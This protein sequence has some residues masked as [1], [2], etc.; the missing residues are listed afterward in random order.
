M[1]PCPPFL[2][3]RNAE[4]PLGHAEAMPSSPPQLLSPQGR[5]GPASPTPSPQ[6]R[7]PGA[8]AS[9]VQQCRSPSVEQVIEASSSEQQ[10][11]QARIQQDPYLRFMEGYTS[12]I[13]PDRMQEILVRM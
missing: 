5:G 9:P 11:S 3:Q 8:L 1:R 7:E 6:S 2:Q 13:V 12:H 4:S 10:R